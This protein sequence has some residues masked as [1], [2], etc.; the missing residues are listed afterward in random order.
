M[1]THRPVG[2]QVIRHG[3]A[4]EARARPHSGGLGSVLVALSQQ[5]SAVV[6]ESQAQTKQAREGHSRVMKELED[7]S[8]G[9]HVLEGMAEQARVLQE[10]FHER[11]VL[12]PVF[13]SLI[14]I[15]DR[16]RRE[17]ARLAN[18]ARRCG[19]DL[20]LELGL[21]VRHLVS[22]RKADLEEI[23]TVLA[24]FGVEV[25]RHPGQDFNAHV[26]TCVK[27]VPVKHGQLTGQIAERLLP[28]YQR[29]EEIIQAE[30]V[31]VYVLNN[32]S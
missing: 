10:R 3:K 32:G 12:L 17:R 30:R 11:E 1:I 19:Q 16:L 23:E 24:N 15:A 28:G 4:G 18:L 26:Q 21:T 8:L 25:F 7:L 14:G 27:P 20:E 29:G 9:K 13:C 5:L 6:L 31:N 2:R 22:A